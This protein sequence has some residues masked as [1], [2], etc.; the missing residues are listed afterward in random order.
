[1]PHQAALPPEEVVEFDHTLSNE[2]REI[3]ALEAQ[4]VCL[5]HIFQVL[6][7]IRDKLPGP[8]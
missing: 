6:G 5:F 4:A 8:P 1:M 2:D 3:N 7:E